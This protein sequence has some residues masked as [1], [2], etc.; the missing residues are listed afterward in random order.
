M[1]ENPADGIHHVDSVSLNLEML[2][3]LLP[4]A[5]SI[6]QFSSQKS[7]YVSFRGGDSKNVRIKE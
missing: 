5:R 4:S 3:F 1:E 7:N 6:F 2:L